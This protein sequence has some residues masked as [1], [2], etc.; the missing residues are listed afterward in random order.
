M[1]SFIREKTPF[2]L[3]RYVHGPV[4]MVLQ[5]PG[6]HIEN[7]R[8]FDEPVIFDEPVYS[9]YS[10]K[11][12]PAGIAVGTRNNVEVRTPERVTGNAVLESRLFHP[13]EMEELCVV[14]HVTPGLRITLDDTDKR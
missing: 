6:Y 10:Q 1:S 11:E 3:N 12:F 7:I 5:T 4:V 13:A 2:T 9:P 8:K 14:Q